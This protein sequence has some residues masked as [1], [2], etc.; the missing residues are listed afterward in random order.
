VRVYKLYLLT[1]FSPTFA[2]GQPRTLDF[3]TDAAALVSHFEHKPHL[4]ILCL[5]VMWK[6]WR[7]PENRKYI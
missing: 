2:T 3:A 1:Y 7:R 6:T 4:G 5:A